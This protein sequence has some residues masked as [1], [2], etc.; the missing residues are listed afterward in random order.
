M[1]YNP[2]KLNYPQNKLIYFLANLISQLNQN[3]KSK[4][5]EQKFQKI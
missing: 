1:I 5:L 3:L 2:Q 4:H